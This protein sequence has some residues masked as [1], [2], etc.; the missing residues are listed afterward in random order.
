MRITRTS[1]KIK[2]DEYPTFIVY[3]DDINGSMLMF[4][5]REYEDERE[6]Y[7]DIYTGV[8]EC[9]NVVK[10]ENEKFLIDDP[11]VQ[12]LPSDTKLEITI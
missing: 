8:D 10:W 4:V 2:P 11:C 6:R 1:T 7:D 9:A 5:F 12:F 3:T